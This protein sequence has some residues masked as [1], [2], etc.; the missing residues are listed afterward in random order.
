MISKDKLMEVFDEKTKKLVEI[1][2]ET[3]F[4]VRSDLKYNRE[5]LPATE[6]FFTGIRTIDTL[7]PICKGKSAGVLGASGTGEEF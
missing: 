7:Y 6:R 5:R 3:K 1:T 4:P 2:M